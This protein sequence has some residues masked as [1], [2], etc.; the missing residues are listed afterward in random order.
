M[1]LGASERS[2]A[3]RALFGFLVFAGVLIS[4]ALP[5]TARA[6]VPVGFTPCSGVSG[7]FCGSIAV[8]VDRSGL[9]IPTTTTIS[10]HVMW[11]PARVADTDGALV[12]LAGGPGQ[13]ATPFAAAFAIALAPALGTR[14]LIVFDQRGTGGSGT[15]DCPGAES[16]P[17]LEQF[18]QACAAEIGAAR[19]Y[20]TSKDSAEDLDAVRTAVGVDKLTVFGVSYGTYVAQIYARLFPEHTSALVLDSVVPS[21]GLDPFLRPNFA[22]IPEVLAANCAKK[23]CRGITKDPFGDLKQLVARAHV[24]KELR[25]HY[26][27]SHGEVRSLSAT[28]V[29]LLSFMTDT[30]T[31]DAV[32]RARFPAAVRSALVGD[33]YPLGRL[34]APVTTPA[35]SNARM[36]TALFLSTTCTETSFPWSPSDATSIRESKVTSALAT[37]PPSAFSPFTSD[38]ALALSDIPL[39]VFWP[40]PQQPVDPTVA[41]PLPNVPT[42]ILD[43]EEDD[44]TPVANGVEVAS[45]LPQANRVSVPFT[46]HS[47]IGDIWPDATTCVEQ[48]L[49]SFFASMPASACDFVTPFFRPTGPDPTSLAQVKPVRI[50]GERG[51]TVGAVLGTLSDVTMTELSG[52][53][54]DAG[55]RG[56]HFSGSNTNLRL[57]KVV[58]VPGVMVSGR[59]DL[60]SGKA[61]VTVTGEGARGKIVIHRYKSITTVKG[62]LDGKRFSIK[63]RTSANDSTVATLLPGLL[64]SSLV[65]RS[66]SLLP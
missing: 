56:G 42:L 28:Q 54:N 27:D 52:M 57:S 43:G 65:T 51:R 59:F 64:G 13:A 53:E 45:L 12:A 36:S 39:C 20:Y 32:A 18:V 21:T 47:V 10:L 61:T 8:P 48:S 19:A 5:A 4:L 29:D 44:L 55:L 16:A 46:G 11:K 40:A 24:K 63:T 23:L 3:G 25:L 37:I 6:A 60:V 31:F 41:A 26:V 14:D 66:L 34:L 9:V 30:F 49:T 17:S 38:A 58:Y 50:K 35:V 22:A 15:L 7:F 1:N 2:R 33:P 62:K